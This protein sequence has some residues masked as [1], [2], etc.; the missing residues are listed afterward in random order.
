MLEFCVRP[1]CGLLNICFQFFSAIRPNQYVP[2]NTFYLINVANNRLFLMFTS[3]QTE[4][5]PTPALDKQPQ[6]QIVQQDKI[7]SNIKLYMYYTHTLCIRDTISGVYVN[8]AV[9][10]SVSY[11]QIVMN[12]V[13][14]NK[15]LEPLGALFIM[16]L[17]SGL[18]RD[19]WPFWALKI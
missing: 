12:L 11:T 10:N 5:L 13:L 7:Y 2:Q 3:K 18:A 16:A 1:E 9:I 4:M 14:S 15:V 6:V 19:F 8:L 17:H